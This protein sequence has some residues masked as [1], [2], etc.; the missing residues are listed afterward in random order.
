VEPGAPAEIEA[1]IGSQSD[2]RNAEEPAE[3]RPVVEAGAAKAPAVVVDGKYLTREPSPNE[4]L[5]S[6]GAP[7]PPKNVAPRPPNTKGRSLA[8]GAA[9]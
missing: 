8:S 6:E 1:Q 2:H 5:F 9:R 4:S 7:P 3:A